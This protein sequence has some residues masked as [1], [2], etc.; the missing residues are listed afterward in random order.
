MGVGAGEGALPPPQQRNHYI[1]EIM[2]KK[3]KKNNRKY[4]YCAL[5]YVPLNFITRPFTH[6]L[7]FS[8]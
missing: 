1:C 6:C 8:N 2:S 3:V 5:Q 4:Q 7:I